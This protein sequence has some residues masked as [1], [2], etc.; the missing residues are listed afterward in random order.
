MKRERDPY[1]MGKTSICFWGMERTVLRSDRNNR[2]GRKRSSF[3]LLS[4]SNLNLAYKQVRANGG[5]GGVDKMETE[6]LRPYL[7]AQSYIT[8]VINRSIMGMME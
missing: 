5:S 2:V 6:D 1:E 8:E 3:F 4:S 7:K